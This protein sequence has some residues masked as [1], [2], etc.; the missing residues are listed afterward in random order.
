MKKSKSLNEAG[1]IKAGLKRM[2]RRVAG[3]A[4]N[5]IGLRGSEG[6]M[7]AIDTS[8]RVARDFFNYAAE[9][10]IPNT[11][12][13]I[14]T[15]A[16]EHYGYE[17]TKDVVGKI[18]QT[19]G[20]PTSTEQ[21]QDAQ[22]QNSKPQS[23]TKPEPNA[24]N[25]TQQTQDK[26]DAA[27]SQDQEPQQAPQQ[28]QTQ[29]PQPGNQN[30]SNSTIGTVGSSG[31]IDP[32]TEYN[33][34]TQTQPT[35]PAGTQDDN[36]DVNPTA[37]TKPRIRVP[38][39]SSKTQTESYVDFLMKSV[40]ME[41]TSPKSVLDRGSMDKIFDII[42]RDMLRRGMIDYD[43]D[44]ELDGQRRPHQRSVQTPNNT[45]SGYERGP[46][47]P[48]VGV[49]AVKFNKLMADAGV[50]KEEL[51]RIQDLSKRYNNDPEALASALHNQK[52]SELAKK[53]MAAAIM[54]LKAKI[55]GDQ[56]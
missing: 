11:L 17:P 35:Q 22:A 31:S 47:G 12:M 34:D 54:A 41:N 44:P 39:G 5:A 4:A 1:E 7:R 21:R 36:V 32:N 16:K 8:A 24:A 46:D 53:V 18:Y 37:A 45:P 28:T 26:A 14:M 56:K 3:A 33:V 49:D 30:Q 52:D 29:Q 10:K 13:N 20:W 6:N 50:T 2:G 19:M 51:A 15:F 55:G 42:A 43:H 23:Q 9:Q 25:Q 48:V 27:R 38:A 40:L